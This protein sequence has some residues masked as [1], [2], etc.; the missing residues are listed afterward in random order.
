VY[1]K[2]PVKLL[3]VTVLIGT[4]RENLSWMEKY[5]R[6]FWG[7]KCYKTNINLRVLDG[8]P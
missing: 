6:K 7:K 4:V 3:R 5:L 8:P 1:D 2:G